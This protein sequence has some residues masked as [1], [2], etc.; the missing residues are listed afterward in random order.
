ML[1]EVAFHVPVQNVFQPTSQ[2]HSE[3]NVLIQPCFAQKHW[4]P[5]EKGLGSQNVEAELLVVFQ[6]LSILLGIQAAIVWITCYDTPR[7]V[8][9]NRLLRKFHKQTTNILAKTLDSTSVSLSVLR[10]PSMTS[11][12]PAV[13]VFRLRAALWNL[14]RRL[15]TTPSNLLMSNK[16]TNKQ[17]TLSEAF[18]LHFDKAPSGT[19]PLSFF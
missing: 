1:C 3:T 12:L 18:P 5:C 2:S 16:Q 15:T 19:C 4:P 14:G 9:K 11:S 10:M 6:S 17:G 7:F 13:P 8:T